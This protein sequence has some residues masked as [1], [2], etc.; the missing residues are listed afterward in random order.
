M[1]PLFCQCCE[2][3][4]E[5]P[6][7]FLKGTSRF[8]VCPKGMLWFECSCGSG[9]ILKKGEFEWYS[10]TLQM[11]EAAATIFKDVQEIRNIPL[12]PT[13]ILSLQ[14]A[15]S[16]DK[17]SS[18]DIKR[19]L[20]EAPN[21]AMGVI[22]KANILRASSAAEFSSLE[23]AI[24]FIGRRTLNDL[25]LAETLQEFDFKTH[26][27]SKDVYWQ[28]SIL[29]GKIAEYLAQHY[30]KNVS[31][32]EAYIAGSLCNIGKVVSAICFPNVTDDVAKST[33]NPRRPKTWVQSEDDLRAIS[34]VVLGE[35][36][37]ALW[38][39]PEYVV[40]AISYHHTVPKRVAEISNQELEFLDDVKDPE[41]AKNPTLQQVVAIANQFAHWVMLQPS[42]MDEPLFELYAKIFHLD[43]KGRS[44]LA[45]KLMALNQKEAV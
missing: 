14:N 18:L 8:R 38:G 3:I 33:L 21:I 36:A 44:T 35:V 1:K 9:L 13:A 24:S 32:D 30:A 19:A 43:E 37:A 10:P 6:E 25:I 20:K 17:S 5:S 16:D 27:F 42:R 34:H 11:N 31:K 29:T 39:F 2:R 45:D 7:D 26:Y 12:I 15:I 4:Y 23:H 28:E 22:R 41:T 40:H